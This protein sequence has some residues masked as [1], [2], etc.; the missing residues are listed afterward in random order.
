MR[1]KSAPAGTGVHPG[2]VIPC[3]AVSGD[4]LSSETR[5]ANVHAACYVCL[6]LGF[7]FLVCVHVAGPAANW[8]RLCSAAVIDYDVVDAAL[9]LSLGG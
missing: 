6:F 3:R 4:G 5:R 9:N 2:C 1:A 7:F 8:Q